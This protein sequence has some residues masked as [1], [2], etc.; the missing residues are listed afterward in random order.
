ML[1]LPAPD[2]RPVGAW[3]RPSAPFIEE[4][5]HW[6]RPRGKVLEVGAGNGLLAAHLAARGVEVLATTRFSSHDAHELGLYFPVAECEATEAVLRYGAECDVLL[7]CWPTTSP[8]ALH[9]ARAWGST[10]PIVFIGEV[11]SP[12]EGEFGGCATDEF[13]ASVRV[14][15]RFATYCGNRLEAAFSCRFAPTQRP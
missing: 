2:E 3:W 4:L 15:D 8:A 10:R 1:P 13:F 11:S 14:E 9:A 7:L 5:A 12:E 6:M